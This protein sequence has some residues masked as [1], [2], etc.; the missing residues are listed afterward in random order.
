MSEPVDILNGPVD[1]YNGILID[2][3]EADIR[4]EQFREQ[5]DSNVLSSIR[6]SQY[7]SVSIRRIIGALGHKFIQDHLVQSGGWTFQHCADSSRGLIRTKCSYLYI[8]RTKNYKY[9]L[10]I[11]EWVRLPP[12]QSRFCDD[13]QVAA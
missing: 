3:T 7:W 1:R 9:F 4:N 11:P 12:C 8:V 10:S 6:L 13:G 5:L 2:T